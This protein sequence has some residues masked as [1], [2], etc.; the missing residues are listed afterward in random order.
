M[1]QILVVSVRSSSDMGL[2]GSGLSMQ[3]SMAGRARAE[4]GQASR[5]GTRVVWFGILEA[6]ERPFAAT[7]LEPNSGRARLYGLVLAARTPA[8]LQWVECVEPEGDTSSALCSELAHPL[9]SERRLVGVGGRKTLGE[10]VM[11]KLDPK[12]VARRP[13]Q[14]VGRGVSTTAPLLLECVR[15]KPCNTLTILGRASDGDVDDEELASARVIAKQVGEMLEEALRL[16]VD[17]RAGPVSEP[18]SSSGLTQLPGD[19]CSRFQSG[20]A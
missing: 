1:L 13:N 6:E 8:R 14:G 3:A 11:V 9:R 20:D 2:E 4:R 10:E 18:V 7:S 19:V 17:E 16:R 15:D 12:C 5:T